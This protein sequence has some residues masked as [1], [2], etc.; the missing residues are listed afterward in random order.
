MDALTSHRALK[1]QTVVGEAG[2]LE[3]ATPLP[4]GTRVTIF[5]IEE[6]S[7]TFGDLLHADRS[8]LA[9]WDNPYDH[10]DWQVH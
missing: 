6:Q 2:R 9:F 7:D 4:P 5:V 8:N 1:Y 10:E 3:I